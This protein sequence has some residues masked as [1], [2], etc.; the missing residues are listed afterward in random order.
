MRQKDD[1]KYTNGERSGLLFGLF[2]RL[3]RSPAFTG[4]PVDIPTGDRVTFGMPIVFLQ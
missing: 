1:D 4:R 2:G 3:R